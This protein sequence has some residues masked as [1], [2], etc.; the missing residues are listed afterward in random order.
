MVYC[1]GNI[2]KEFMLPVMVY[3]HCHTRVHVYVYEYA[4]AR[5]YVCVWTI[6]ERRAVDSSALC[7]LSSRHC[8][9]SEHVRD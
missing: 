4:H 1:N 5:V 6:T 3:S 2:L 7:S 8:Y 9:T